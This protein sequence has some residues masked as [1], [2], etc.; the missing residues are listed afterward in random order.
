MCFI[1]WLESVNWQYKNNCLFYVQAEN[2][3]DSKKLLAYIADAKY[4]LG[5]I[6]DIFVVN[7]TQF[8]GPSESTVY[9]KNELNNSSMGIQS[10]IIVVVLILPF[11]RRLITMS[12]GAK[13]VGPPQKNSL[14]PLLVAPIIYIRPHPD[15]EG[16]TKLKSLHNFV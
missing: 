7:N 15:L 8:V 9:F 5:H 13:I 6:V 3:G 2:L 4:L 14:G 10:L 12:G 16:L 1:L 11:C